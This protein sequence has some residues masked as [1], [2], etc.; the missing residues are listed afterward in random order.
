MHASGAHAS[1]GWTPMARPAQHSTAQRG[2]HDAIHAGRPGPAAQRSLTHQAMIP[3]SMREGMPSMRKSHCQP[4][5]PFSPSR[6]RQP[7]ASGAA[8]T[9]EMAMPLST[10]ARMHVHVC[11]G[12]SAVRSSAQA[13][14]P[15]Y[16]RGVQKAPEGCA[17]SQHMHDA[18]CSMAP[19]RYEQLQPLAAM[20]GLRRDAC[21][22]MWACGHGYLRMAA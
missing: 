18:A 16:W 14:A 7:A 1:R 4:A 17:G 19:A 3:D 10:T 13:Q 11:G 12:V 2:A 6:L 15:R 22:G 8:M 9:C 5:S 20:R 21:A